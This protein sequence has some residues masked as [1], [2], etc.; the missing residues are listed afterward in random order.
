MRNKIILILVFLFVIISVTAVNQEL[1]KNNNVL[2]NNN[3]INI[4]QINA[5]ILNQED[6][7]I[8]NQDIPARDNPSLAISDGLIHYWN[9][10]EPDDYIIKDIVD[11]WNLRVR[12]PFFTRWARGKINNSI[13]FYHSLN[14]IDYGGHIGKTISNYDEE[15]IWTVSFWIKPNRNDNNDILTLLGDGNGH[16]N[17]AYIGIKDIENNLRLIAKHNDEN[18]NIN[19]IIGNTNIELETWNYI[20]VIYNHINN[21]MKIYLNGVSDAEEVNINHLKLKN[22]IGITLGYNHIR[23]DINID[24]LGIWNR[25]LTPQEIQYLYNSGQGIN[26]VNQEQRNINPILLEMLESYLR[27][28]SIEF[29]EEMQAGNNIPVRINVRFDIPS[30][31]VWTL[32]NLYAVIDTNNPVNNEPIRVRFPTIRGGG[33]FNGRTYT[34]TANLNYPTPNVYNA[35]IYLEYEGRPWQRRSYE[36]EI[37]ENENEM[38]PVFY[39]FPQR[40]MFQENEEYEID[41]NNY[42]FDPNNDEIT[43]NIES[44]NIEISQEGNILTFSAPEDYTGQENIILIADDGRLESRKEIL[45]T[46]MA[47][48]SNEVI[49]DGISYYLETD[50]TT[51]SLND[52]NGN[53]EPVRML[54]RVTNLRNENVGIYF[55]GSS[56]VHSFKVMDEDENILWFRES[57]LNLR[58]PIE[59]DLNQGESIEFNTNEEYW[60]Y[61]P[62]N[63]INEQ[64]NNDPDDDTPVEPGRYEII[65]SLNP[66][67]R[68]FIGREEVEIEIVPV[69][70]FVDVVE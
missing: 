40:I 56:R 19:E 22:I 20:T 14:I 23:T 60:R 11:G 13:R 38:P 37:H 43:Y 3:P 48:N 44:E 39:N 34:V 6:N 59:I 17:Y 16:N 10:N 4:K 42:V 61:G 25:E 15:D 41:I 58:P 2:V 18:R 68:Y 52:E 63:L 33:I 55:G 35:R 57:R 26:P 21:K 7:T 65:S 29:P 46:V 5:N 62:W 32:N 24:E 36:L 30:N 1:S 53:P 51:Y 49:R 8:I 31:K 64:E 66:I 50:K 67:G 54:F 70:V 12:E 47:E 27:V 45:V 69:S 9:F 28:E